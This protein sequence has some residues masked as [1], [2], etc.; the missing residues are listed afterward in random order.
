MSVVII[1]GNERMERKYKD[2]CSEYNCKAKVFTKKNGKISVGNPDLLIFF[3]DT[4]SHKMVFNAKESV[5]GMNV[6]VAHCHS[7]SASALRQVLEQHFV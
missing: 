1:G 4:V 3:T 7:S 6:P 5:K 2:L